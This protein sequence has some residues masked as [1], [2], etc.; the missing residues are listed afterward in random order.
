MLGGSVWTTAHT[1]GRRETVEE[2][3]EQPR[4]PRGKRARQQEAKGEKWG[5]KER[6]NQ[7][8]LCSENTLHI[9]QHLSQNATAAAT[10]PLATTATRTADGRTGAPQLPIALGTL[11]CASSTV[12]HSGTIVCSS[13]STSRLISLWMMKRCL[14]FT[15]MCMEGGIQ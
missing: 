9:V 10:A 8:R 12:R 13:S 3:G 2:C 4:E 15:A 6:E 7:T 14:R 11:S 1:Y 5:Q